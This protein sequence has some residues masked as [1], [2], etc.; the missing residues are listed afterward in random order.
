MSWTR[1][2]R[3]RGH[4]RGQCLGSV[5]GVGPRILTFTLPVSRQ[6]CQNAA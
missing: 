3:V 5:F 1:D 2:G 6:S 4:A